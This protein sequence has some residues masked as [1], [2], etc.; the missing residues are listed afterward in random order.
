MMSG[1]ASVA[2]PKG[3]ARSNQIRRCISRK[4]MGF[5]KVVPPVDRRAKASQS[6]TIPEAGQAHQEATMGSS[7]PAIPQK[8]H[9]SNQ[10]TARR[11]WNVRFPV[12]MPTMKAIA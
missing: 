5:E 9:V 2:I 10:A 11:P 3:N 6:G 1:Q 4:R 7:R 12:R 8:I